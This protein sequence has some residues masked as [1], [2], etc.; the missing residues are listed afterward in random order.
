MG[1]C[2]VSALHMTA[3]WMQHNP[4]KT[5]PRLLY[6]QPEKAGF[7]ECEPTDRTSQ[8]SSPETHSHQTHAHKRRHRAR[9]MLA[10]CISQ[11]LA[12]LEHTR[13][14]TVGGLY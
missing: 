5:I 12:K 7:H 2:E 11:L 14:D 4:W 3:L 13:R 1:S 10:P 6:S 9:E 8:I